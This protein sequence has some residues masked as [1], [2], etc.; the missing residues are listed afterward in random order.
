M[1]I[2]PVK[3]EDRIL[4]H[5]HGYI[6]FADDF[7]VPRGMSQKGIG[8]AIWIAWSNV[9]RAMRR[10]V[11]EDLVEERTARVKGE[12]R[13]KK[14]YML[15]PKGFAHAKGL[16]EEHG[17][18]T[19]RVLRDGSAKD[20]PF[21]ELADAPGIKVPYLELLRGI[22][23]EGVLDLDKAAARFANRVEM[24]DR[25]E[26]APRPRPFV[27]REEELADLRELLSSHRV[28]VVHGMAGIGKTSLAVRLLADL[29]AQTNVLWVTVRSDDPM[30]V[31]L[32]TVASFLADTG[33]RATR[34]YIDGHPTPSVGDVYNTLYEDLS[35][36]KGVLVFDDFHKASA[37]VTE[38]FKAMMEAL[39][40]RPS[41]S[42][43]LL[44][45]T[46]PSFY[47]RRWVVVKK[48]VGELKLKGLDRPSARAL[49]EGRAL[50]DAEFDRIYAKT[51][52]HP[53]ALELL[54]E[55]R[56]P[57]HLGEVM[58]FVR[59]E[60]FESLSAAEKRTLGA[61]SVHRGAVPQQFAIDAASRGGGVEA[62]D[63]LRRRGLVMDVGGDWVDVHDL[64]RE[65]FYERL[66]KEERV[67]LHASAADAWG[68]RRDLEAT[69]ERA[70]H[71][72]RSGDAERAIRE[73]EGQHDIIMGKP[74]LLRDVLAI[75]DMAESRGDLPAALSGTVDL[76]KGDALAGL[77]QVDDATTVY[78]RLLDGLVASGDHSG[79]GR[80]LHRLGILTA[81]RGQLDQALELQR[82]AR[83]AFEAAEDAVG[84]ARCRLASADILD[85]RERPSEAT[86]ELQQAIKEFESAE[87][88]SGVAL[89]CTRLG[90][91]LIDQE[92]PEDARPLLERAIRGLDRA[93]EPGALA[94]AHYLLGEACRQQ[95][96]WDGAVASYELALE[97]ANLAGDERMTTN[98][99]NGLG[100]A[101]MALGDRPR[102]DMFHK[103][104]LDLMV[105]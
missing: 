17:R 35:D 71:I 90:G 79:E 8:E 73:L 100:D 85:R 33:R 103:R 3:V 87:D 50:S 88:R 84:A 40:D 46:I 29:R 95:E 4:L 96:R 5:L 47:D 27:G 69:V 20:I 91:M 57:A 1:G 39:E 83:K 67:A 36:L 92:R 24:V 42:L 65:F 80:I 15:T 49:L 23:G 53:L 61:L 21:A 14:V 58:E 26:H 63:E 72:A 44:S 78:T 74:L 75:L 38:L 19:V 81:R 105:A 12:F 31:I 64:V 41:P 6:R 9:P 2:E 56:R 77:H 66:T 99:C 52:G 89:A 25:T 51:E 93:A 10:L 60:V 43:L 102:A 11:E 34:S 59:E 86:R 70:H 37:Q 48:V 22:D 32:G 104:A 97:L 45:R 18:R 28:V 68:G 13:K 55:S 82:R 30:P 62:L 54:R 94:H 16:R 98:A 76:I 7:E 101:Y